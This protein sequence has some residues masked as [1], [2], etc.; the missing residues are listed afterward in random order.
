MHKHICLI[1]ILNRKGGIG[2]WVTGEE[3]FRWILMARFQR[4]R[5]IKHNKY[6]KFL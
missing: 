6:Q 5:K 2:K 4:R 1:K 3:P